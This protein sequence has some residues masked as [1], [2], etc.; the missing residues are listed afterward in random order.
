MNILNVIKGF[1]GTHKLASIITASVVGVGAI[2][3]TTVGVIHAVNS[4]KDD[5]TKVEATTNVNTTDMT[6]TALEG[7]EINPADLQDVTEE[8]QADGTTVIKDKNGTVVAK[9]DQSGKTTLTKDGGVALASGSMQASGDLA[10]NVSNAQA[11]TQS[12]VASMPS[13][14]VS[15]TASTP[16]STPSP[17]PSNNYVAPS[18]PI[19]SQPVSCSHNWVTV[20]EKSH[21]VHHDA[22][23]TEADVPIKE[24]KD[25]ERCLVCGYEELTE[26]DGVTKLAQHVYS[27]HNGQANVLSTGKMVVVGYK[28]VTNKVKD[29]WDEKVVDS[30]A[31]TYCSVCGERR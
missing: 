26:N 16:S 8:V 28:H 3:G 14:D 5:D 24:P 1:V 11:Q 21:I 20:P 7:Q 19:F 18:T 12:Y 6:A 23:Y 31:Y 25:V 10:N 30:P 29:E 13:N 4:N 22:E 27:V 9:K 2:G 17:A 15:Y